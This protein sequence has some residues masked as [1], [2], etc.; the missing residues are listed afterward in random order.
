MNDT[1]ECVLNF[2]K[3]QAQFGSTL[4][5]IWEKIWIL[6]LIIATLTYFKLHLLTLK[7]FK[8]ANYKMQEM[9]LTYKE[10]QGISVN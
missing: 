5:T 4:F 1:S 3:F 8:A 9:L 6:S 10:Y 7:D 2:L